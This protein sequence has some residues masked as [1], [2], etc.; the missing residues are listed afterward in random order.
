MA[1]NDPEWTQELWSAARC[2][3]VLL[4]LLLLF[5]WGS[6]RLTLWRAVLWCALAGLLFVVVFPARVSAGGNWL[7]TRRLVREHRVRTD[8]LVSIRCLD[9]I[10]PRLLLRDSLGGRV[11]LDPE[12]L[13]RHP[14]LWLRLE[15]GARKAAADG[16]L[17]CGVTALR[18]ISRRVDGEAARAVLRAS[19]LE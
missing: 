15:A 19:G 8:L 4:A 14:Q 2:A 6:D 16:S 10:S 3:G 18:H 13:V 9:G 17:L 11:E 5:D 7:A 1:T 12:V